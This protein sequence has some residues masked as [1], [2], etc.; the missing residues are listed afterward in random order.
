MA[1]HIMQPGILILKLIVAKMEVFLHYTL[2]KKIKKITLTLKA[3]HKHKLL[4]Y[5]LQL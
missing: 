1:Q 4:K 2:K 3:K 5:L